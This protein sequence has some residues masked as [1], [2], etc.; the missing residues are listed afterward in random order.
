ML[1]TWLRD[2]ILFIKTPF[3]ILSNLLST[4][5]GDGLKFYSTIEPPHW[6]FH[7]NYPEM[8]KHSFAIWTYRY[9]ATLFQIELE[10]NREKTPIFYYPHYYLIKISVF[11]WESQ[12][13]V[14][15]CSFSSNRLAFYFV[16]MCFEFLRTVH[17]EMRAQFLWYASL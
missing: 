4:F 13:L 10:S 9:H 5:E 17:K 14:I 8:I 16:W 6:T 15:Q 1:F 7:H 2:N 11:V 3:L 12:L